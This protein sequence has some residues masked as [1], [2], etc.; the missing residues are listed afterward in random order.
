MLPA[1]IVDGNN[2]SLRKGVRG[3]DRVVVI[4]GDAKRASGLGRSREDNHQ[5][6][7]ESPRDFSSSFI[8]DRIAGQINGISGFLGAYQKSSDFAADRFKACWTMPG[9]CRGDEKPMSSFAFD[10][11][12][13]P[14][15]EAFRVSA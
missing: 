12:R 2:A 14:R 4:H 3:L 15:G 7:R 11:R 5:A 9:W 10:G 1:V 13:L 6:G 8:P